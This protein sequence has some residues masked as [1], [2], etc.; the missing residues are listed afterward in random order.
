MADPEHAV[1]VLDELKAAGI[2]LSV[3][4]FGTGYSSLSYLRRFPLDE[5]KIDRS[6]VRDVATDP[7][8]AAIARAII[9]MAHRLGLKVVAEGVET[10]EQLEFLRASGCDQLQG[11]FIARPAGAAEILPLL[12][13]PGPR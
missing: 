13:R 3:D 10:A 11:Y 5:L 1:G 4:D 8:D 2:A 6:F 7:N 9:S 12:R